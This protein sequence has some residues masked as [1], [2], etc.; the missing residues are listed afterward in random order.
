MNIS[1]PSIIASMINLA[2]KMGKLGNE[3]NIYPLKGPPYDDFVHINANP[4]ANPPI[5]DNLP[6]GR[7][8]M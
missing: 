1:P 2:L 6:L 4:T 3:E 8:D 7:K 5:L